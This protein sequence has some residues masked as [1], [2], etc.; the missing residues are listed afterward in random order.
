MILFPM[1]RMHQPPRAAS[2]NK[3]CLHQVSHLRLS[4]SLYKSHSHFKDAHRVR[5]RSNLLPVFAATETDRSTE[6]VSPTEAAPPEVEL[7]TEI[8]T[9]PPQSEIWELDFSSRPVLDS[10]GKKKWELLIC[11]SDGSWQFSRYFP[12]NKI[13]STQVTLLLMTLSASCPSLKSLSDSLLCCTPCAL[14]LGM[15]SSW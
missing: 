2:G 14:S 13:N 7:S 6:A 5:S 12:N 9:G 1:N 10:R 3:C 15:S 11:S 4:C 8:N